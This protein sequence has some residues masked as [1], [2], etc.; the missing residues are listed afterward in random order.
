[1]FQLLLVSVITGPALSWS[2]NSQSNRLY[3][4]VARA[5]INSRLDSSL[6]KVI[7]HNPMTDKFPVESFHHLEFYCSDAT[8]AFNRFSSGLG[9][10]LI[11]KSDQST[12]N[13]QYLSFCLNSGDV[14]IV[15]TSPNNL[16]IRPEANP[17]DLFDLSLPFPLFSSKRINRF[18]SQHGTGVGVVALTVSDVEASYASLLSG[19]A[20]SVAQPH[21]GSDKQGSVMMAEVVLYGDTV[22]RLVDNSHFHGTFLPNFHDVEVNNNNK[23]S[24][25]VFDVRR[26]VW[27]DFG[28]RKLDHVVGN[29]PNLASATKY[30]KRMTVRYRYIE[31]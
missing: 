4:S 23:N 24:S 19:G 8:T 9:M 3:G 12:G 14:N 26:R 6:G 18:I 31:I 11:A 5:S 15:F 25:S 16:Y 7:R 2:F 10:N 1:M 28:L 29:V 30:I 13:N 27:R 21:I 20:R 22:L 17:T